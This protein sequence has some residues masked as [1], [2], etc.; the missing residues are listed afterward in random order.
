MSIVTQPKFSLSGVVLG[1]LI[2]FYVIL[3]S[4]LAAQGSSSMTEPSPVA[5]VNFSQITVNGLNFRIAVAGDSGPLMLLAHGWPE[6]WYNWRHQ[7]QFFSQRGYRVVAPD[8]RGYGSTDAPDAVEAYDIKTLAADMVGILDTLGEERAIMVGHD[9]GSI[10]AWNTVLMYPD[11]F[12][13]LIAMSVPYSGRPEQSPLVSWRE[14]FADNF[15]YILYHNEPEGVAEAE[16]DNNPYGL[17]SRLYLSPDSP[18]RAPEVSDPRR[19][20]GGWIPRLGVPVDLPNWLEQSDLDYVV[21]EFE[22]SGFRGG[23]NYYRN[24]HRNWEIT[25]DLQD[26]RITIPTL[27]VAGEK[28]VVIAGANRGRLQG[29]MERVVDDLREVVLLPGI[30][31]WV[32]QEAPDEVNQA[33]SDFLT[34]INVVP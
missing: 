26:S 1:C 32:Q 24:F 9:W 19:A 8:M 25:A 14:A 5:G 6:S 10:V 17:I 27:F 3:S 15:Y 7:L 12:S 30:G 11:R 2:A 34:E 22:R 21:S 13:G 23:V 29:A 28:D 31:H 4:P 33:M 20:A 18:R 16:Y